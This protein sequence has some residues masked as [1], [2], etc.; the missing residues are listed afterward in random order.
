MW[1]V[2]LPCFP[3]LVVFKP[4]D[5]FF[6]FCSGVSNLEELVEVTNRACGG[7]HTLI[8]QH[9]RNPTKPPM[10]YRD[11]NTPFRQS[12]R[13]LLETE[14]RGRDGHIYRGRMQSPVQ[15]PTISRFGIIF[16]PK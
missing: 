14:V 9:R 11:E 6:L 15:L 7:G 13:H 1:Y 4:I 2:F 3:V 16:L 10:V 8:E 5:H 12:D